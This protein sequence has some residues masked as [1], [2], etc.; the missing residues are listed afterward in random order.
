M[1]VHFAMPTASNEPAATAI[2]GPT[3]AFDGH[4]KVPTPVTGPPNGFATNTVGCA[5]PFEA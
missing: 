3:P 5:C 1:A 4:E 2:N